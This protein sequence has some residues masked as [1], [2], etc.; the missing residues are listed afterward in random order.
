MIMSSTMFRQRAPAPSGGVRKVS[1]ASCA[2]GR[3]KRG[4][5]GRTCKRAYDNRHYVSRRNFTG[6]R[7]L[8]DKRADYV[9]PDYRMTVRFALA[10]L[11]KM[12][13]QKIR[14]LITVTSEDREITREERSKSFRI[15]R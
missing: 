9:M 5:R 15:L 4:A 2:S 10:L 12:L 7:F 8:N 6:H 11:H 3:A 1:A 14:R 13:F